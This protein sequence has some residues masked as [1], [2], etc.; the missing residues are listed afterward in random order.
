MEK[1]NIDCTLLAYDGFLYKVFDVG[2]NRRVTEFV[3]FSRIDL[4]ERVFQILERDGFSV[5]Y[6]RHIYAS[7]ALLEF[8]RKVKEKLGIKIMIDIPTYPYDNELSIRSPFELEE[9]RRYRDEIGRYADYCVD[10]GMDEEVY[11][12]KVINLIN[13]VFTENIPLRNPEKS[14]TFRMLCVSTLCYWHGF[15]RIIMGMKRYLEAGGEKRISFRV[16]GDGPEAG[17]LRELVRQNQLEDYVEFSGSII[18]EDKLEDAFNHAD[19]A[20]G[21]IGVHRLNVF[22]GGAIKNQEYCTRGIPFVLTALDLHFPKDAPYIKYIPSSDEDVD[23]NELILFAEKAD[24]VDMRRK[25]RRYAEEHFSWDTIL[26]ELIV[27][28]KE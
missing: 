21:G 27:K 25:M 16:I 14:D 6:V 5:L 8:Y 15:D 17:H 10:Y 22:S 9:D 18:E 11:G 26:K 1:S 28:I 2:E 3:A 23:I 7:R 12:M 24:C 13:G 19:I 20:I 4:F